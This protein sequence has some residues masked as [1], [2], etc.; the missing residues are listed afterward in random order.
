MIKEYHQKWV[1]RDI[2]R[3]YKLAYTTQTQFNTMENICHSFAIQVLK[4]KE[5]LATLENDLHHVRQKLNDNPNHAGHLK[6]LKNIT[7]DITITMNELEHCESKLDE[8]REESI[9]MQSR[10]ND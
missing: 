2:L 4:T 6:A 5:I 1:L 8:C 3:F 10:Y 9:K 7:L